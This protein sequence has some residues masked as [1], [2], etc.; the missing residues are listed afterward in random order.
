M[1]DAIEGSVA[2]NAFE[3][4]TVFQVPFNETGPRRK[5]R[6]FTVAEVVKDRNFMILLHEKS[7]DCA[8]DVPCAACYKNLHGYLSAA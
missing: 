1:H 2:E 7:S 6:C 4:G 3:Q 5:G 8:P